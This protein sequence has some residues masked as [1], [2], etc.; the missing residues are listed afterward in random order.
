MNQ[1]PPRPT[2]ARS[3]TG[4]LRRIARRTLEWGALTLLLLLVTGAAF[5]LWSTRRPFPQVDGAIRLPGLSAPVDVVRDAQGVPHIYASTTEDLLMAQGF[6][7]AQDRFFQMDTWRHIGAG[8]LSEMFGA[9]QVETDSFIRTMGWYDLAARQYDA[10][11]PSARAYLDAYAAGVNAYLEQRSP[12]E[13]GFEYTILEII[14]H[15]YDPEPWSPVDTLVWG[16]VMSWDL[17]GNLDEEIDRA[18]LLGVMSEDEVHALYPAYPDAAPLIVTHDG[19]REGGP[20]ISPPPVRAL[21]VAFDRVADNTELIDAMTGGGGE[22]LGSNSWVVSGDH[23]ASGAPILAN[24]PHLGIRMPSIWYQVGLHCVEMSDA[25]PFAVTGFSFA[26]VPGVVIGHNHRIAWGFT[27]LGPDVMDLYVERI[28]PDNPDQYEV[29]GEWVDMDVRTE[30]VAVAGGDPVEVRVRTTRHGPVVSDVFGRL[31]D[32]DD[33]GI[34]L[35][36]P[37]VVA[38]RWTAL[39]EVPALTDTVFGLNTAE[40]W[41]DFRAAL[42]TFSVPAQNVIYADVDGNIG[43]QAPGIVPVRND[44]D[45]RVPVPGWTDRYEWTGYIDFEDLPRVFNPAEGWIVTANNAVVDGT[46]P[47][48][49]TSDW[50]RGDRA[51]RIV[52]LVSRLEDATLDDMAAIQFDN[53]NL[54]AQRIRP[55]FLAISP[56]S[57]TQRQRAALAVLEAW[58]LDNDASSAGAAVFEAA[59]AQLLDRLFADDLPAG[60]DPRGGTRWSLAVEDLAEPNDAPFWDDL[61]TPDIETRDDIVAAAFAAGVDDVAALLG[62]EPADWTWGALHTATFENETLGQ[63]GIGPIEGRFN[64]GPYPTSGGF[65][66]VNATGWTPSEGFVVD[67]VPSFRMLVDMSDLDGALWVNTTGASGHPYSAHYQD[68][69]E[70]WRTGEYFPMYWSRATVDAA[71]EATLRLVP[72]G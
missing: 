72:A 14:N 51:T 22:G 16:K 70:A 35:P 12:A 3:P 42:S 67:W 38:L 25:C 27:N 66:I 26:G 34:Q 40:N 54:T 69:I 48:L 21:T 58:N 71:A 64:R 24:D 11:S 6:V 30:V 57:M 55:L 45:G 52:E 62:G 4:R 2:G 33:A 65:D 63:S 56:E 7:H 13:L 19:A 31:D 47:Y 50:N 49:L 61:T 23:T 46:Y 10:S 68:Q 28:N 43:Y 29:D 37:Y 5:T 53:R 8:R 39:D 20:G 36:E 41:G 1:T 60:I 32:F 9:D 44:G 15:D 18:L 17:R 59:W